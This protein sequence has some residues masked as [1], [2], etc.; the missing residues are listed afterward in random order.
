MKPS[1]LEPPSPAH[2]TAPDETEGSA[3]HFFWGEGG[4]GEEEEALKTLKRL[5]PS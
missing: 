1:F 5:F 3:V 2:V 4:G